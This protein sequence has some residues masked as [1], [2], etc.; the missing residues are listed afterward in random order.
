ME[1]RT[2][3]DIR[4]VRPTEAADALA[5]FAG[6]PTA[7]TLTRQLSVGA[8]DAADGTLRG[9]A[10]NESL[11]PRSCAVHVHCDDPELGRSLLD[12]ALRKAAAAGR[13]ASRV[14][15]QPE[16]TARA[17]WV[18]SSWPARPTAD[19]TAGEP[20]S[21]TRSPT[22]SPAETDGEVGGQVET[23]ARAKVGNGTEAEVEPA[24]PGPANEAVDAA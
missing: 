5:L 21:Q 3:C 11:G 4:E 2:A 12:R 13:R 10:V 6:G 8:F 16:P 1:A 18:E 15:L 9:A 17:I 20:P 7:A 23:D 14:T 19:P 24:T 22:P